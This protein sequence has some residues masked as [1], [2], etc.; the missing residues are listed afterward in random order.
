MSEVDQVRRNLLTAGAIVGGA[1]TLGIPLSAMAGHASLPMPEYDNLDVTA[2][3]ELLKAGEV[4]PVDLVDAALA[5]FE[6]RSAIN[7][8]A[9]E[10]FD[11]AR[12]QALK[13]SKLGHSV[14]AAQM[15]KVPLQGVPFALKDLYV[16]LKGT[17]TTNGCSFF[18]DDVAAH[19]STLVDR[20]EAAGLNIMAKL[21]SPEFGQTATT[22]STLHGN[23]LNPW[24]LQHS[25]G[26]SSGGS[27]AVVA[28]RILPAAHA[29]DGGGSI[30]I[31]ASHCGLFG[32][33]PSRG[34]VPMGPDVIEGWMGL[35]VHNTVTRT[36]RDSALLL[37]L[38]QGFEAGSRLRHPHENF[39]EAIAAPPKRLRI[40]VMK[41]HPFGLPVHQ[42]C[43][44]AIDKTISLLTDLGHEVVEASPVLPIEA[45]FKGMGVATSTG[46]LRTVSKREK[47]LGRAARE[48]EFEAISWMHLQNAKTYT[49]EQVYAARAA[50]DEGGQVFDR[51]F[52]EYDLLLTAVT[53]TPPPMIGELSLNQPFES[54]V[55]NV[56]KASPITALFNHTGLPAMSVP[57]YWNRE[58]L[59]IGVQVAAPFGGDAML[60]SLAAQLEQAAPWTHRLP[61]MLS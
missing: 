41:A 24:S 10:H 11:R 18:E 25:T 47:A 45:M 49:A 2:M 15:E 44:D 46:L 22:E 42:D 58:G 56:I 26:G 54:F 7:A 17:V 29:S 23:T 55:Q 12:E 8:V 61:A 40:A 16:K 51:F 52:T 31:P 35:S 9:V 14:R 30:R 32:L 5:R 3:V 6:S 57:L 34:R 59:P 60:L 4:T 33:K 36:V 37:Q 13:L 28:A 43:L 53:A 48:D 1:A 27:A 19:N 21:T 20:Y 39:V 50:F 38:T